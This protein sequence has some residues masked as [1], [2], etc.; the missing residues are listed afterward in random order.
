MVMAGGVRKKE[1]W[2]ILGK[3]ARSERDSIQERWAMRDEG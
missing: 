2:G 1:D 3:K